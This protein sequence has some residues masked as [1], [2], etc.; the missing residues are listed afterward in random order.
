MFKKTILLIATTILI[1]GSA[2]A[3]IKNLEGS[4]TCNIDAQ[5]CST[6]CNY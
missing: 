6:S 3:A 4:S 2:F 1:I 5:S